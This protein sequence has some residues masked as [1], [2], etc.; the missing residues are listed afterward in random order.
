MT[1]PAIVTCRA[2]TRS[3]EQCRA[4]DG[5]SADGL[6]ALHDPA[7]AAAVARARRKGSAEK[8][9][10]DLADLPCGGRLATL[11]DCSTWLEWITVQTVT[12]GLDPSKA[13][14]AVKAVMAMRFKLRDE[15]A[16]E[17]RIKALEKALAAQNS[18]GR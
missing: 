16:A 2:Q 5:L 3:G 9:S 7:R 11:E 14:E 6:C 8:A 13:R 18:G 15:L 10:A 1:A 4:R 12:G 17:K